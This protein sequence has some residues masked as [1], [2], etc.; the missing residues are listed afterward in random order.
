MEMR[1]RTTGMQRQMS[2]V[3]W[4]LRSNQPIALAT[5]S[6]WEAQHT[7]RLGVEEP[8]KALLG[9]Q[10]ADA[11]EEIRANN[12]ADRRGDDDTGER[13][14]GLRG[15]K[16]RQRQDELAGDGREHVLEKESAATAR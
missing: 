10:T 4:P 16:A 7:H 13:H 14:L 9:E 15:E 11:V 5:S 6:E 1:L 2:T 12:R 8:L 3:I